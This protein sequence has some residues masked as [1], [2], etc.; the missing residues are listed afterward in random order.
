[1]SLAR[2]LSPWRGTS[3]VD[4]MVSWEEWRWQTNRQEF[5]CKLEKHYIVVVRNLLETL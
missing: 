5:V 2:A 1:M 4:I 3:K